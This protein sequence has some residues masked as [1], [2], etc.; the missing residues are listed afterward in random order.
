[1]RRFADPDFPYQERVVV[2]AD[3][4]RSIPEPPNAGSGWVLAAGRDT[5]TA[6][7]EVQTE[8][9]AWLV[10]PV[11]WHPGWSVTVDGRSVR[12]VQVNVQRIGVPL[13]TGYHEVELRFVPPGFR[14]GAVVTVLT[15]SG[16]VVAGLWWAWERRRQVGEASRRASSKTN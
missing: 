7:A 10:L 13:G 2:A 9:P 1:M 4:L 11:N 15:A 3:Q 14:L 12:P 6:W 16:L 8:G 5:N